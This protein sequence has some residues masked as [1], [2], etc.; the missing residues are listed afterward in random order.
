MKVAHFIDTDS[1]GGAEVLVV[2]ICR[3]LLRYNVETVV[4]HFGNSWLENKCTEYGIASSCLPGYRYYKSITTIPLFAFLLNRFLKNSDIDILHSHLVD[5]IVGSCI[6][7]FLSNTPHVGTLHD[8][9]T[10][11]EQPAKLWLLQLSAF[12][13]TNLITVSSDVERYIMSNVRA[14]QKAYRTI[15]NGVDMARFATADVM[16]DFSF[17]ESLGLAKDDFI[18]VCVGRLAEIKNH[19]SLIKAFSSC[20]FGKNV[21]L[22]IVGDGP[23]RQSIEKLIVTC[24]VSESVKMLGLR[25]DIPELLGISDCFVLSS[26]SEGLSCS[27]IESMAAGLPSIVTNVG[28]NPE[29]VQEGV[30]GYLVDPNNPSALC[31]QMKKMYVQDRE[32]KKMAAA[33]RAVAYDRFS[34]DTMLK[35]YV[36]VYEQVFRGAGS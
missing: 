3:N 10:L 31:E 2:E 32:R 36:A 7:A 26:L 8:V 21:K 29:L 11:K 20:Q 19:E 5:P 14:F 17:K 33:A 12:L 28:G 22:L 27:I 23:L 25:N 4:L 6:G 18:F 9:H 1:V 15:Y 30:T 34:M 16:K 24:D 35:E 13:R